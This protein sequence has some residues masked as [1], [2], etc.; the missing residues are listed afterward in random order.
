MMSAK[1]QNPRYCPHPRI[2]KR[3]NGEIIF[4]STAMIT[5]GMVAMIK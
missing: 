3:L 4:E 2:E 5:A 1:T